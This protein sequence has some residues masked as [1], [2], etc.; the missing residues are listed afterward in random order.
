[1][2]AL[3]VFAGVRGELPELAHHSLFFSRDWEAN[4]ANIVGDGELEP[5][6]P[7]VGVRLARDRPPT[8]APRPQG[9]ENLYMLVPFP[10]DASLGAT[11][12]S[13]A[14]LEEY[15]WRYL[16]Q[17]AAWAVDP[18]PARA[19]HAVPRDRAGTT[20]PRSSVDVARLRAWAGAHRAPVGDVPARATPL[21]DVP[22]LMYVGSSTV[23]G[24]GMPI[25][26]ISAEL[27]AK[28]LLG[29]TSVSPLAHAR[30]ARLPRAVGAPR[31]CSGD[32]A[33]GEGHAA[34]GRKVV[35][36]FAYLAALLVSASPASGFL[37]WR[38]RVA[39]FDQPR[40]ALATLGIG[41]AVFLAWDAL[42][43]GLGIFFIGD[44]P[45]HDRR[46]C[47]RRRFR[48]RRSSSSPCS[49]TRRCWR[50][51]GLCAARARGNR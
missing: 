1:M 45:L 36:H 39:V 7:R 6:V 42:G 3:L 31:T 50:G 21:R 22:N 17:V 46:A 44:N 4:F 37:D 47:W 43:I 26:L 24:I 5:P 34:R 41:V 9:H 8:R 27:V 12:A 19:H 15:A 11:P 48:S 51:C 20:S 10:A 49:C 16:D 14:T 13:R 23:P 29:A 30:S 2:S 18:R 40:R 25:C 32:I 35:M 38:Y 28:R 33:R